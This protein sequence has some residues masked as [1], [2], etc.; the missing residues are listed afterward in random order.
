MSKLTTEQRKELKDACKETLIRKLSQ[1]EAHA[2]VNSKLGFGIS[3][4][5]VQSLRS[6]IGRSAKLELLTLQ[7]DHYVLIQSLFFDRKD[8][9]E[10]MQKVLWSI[11]EKNQLNPEVQIKAIDKLSE[12]TMILT[13]LYH[14][15]PHKVSFGLEQRPYIDRYN[16]KDITHYNIDSKSLMTRD[17]LLELDRREQITADAE[18]GKLFEEIKQK[19][20]TWS[21]ERIYDELFYQDLHKSNPKDYPEPTLLENNP[22]YYK[23]ESKK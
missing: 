20:P 8:E 13:E 3:F 5:Y 4:D 18:Y 19:N 12:L 6:E 2:Y 21:N 22:D 9:L 1:K 10:Q 14:S 11:I 16:F 17:E 23:E 15:L 7:K